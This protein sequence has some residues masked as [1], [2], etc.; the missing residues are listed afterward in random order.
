MFT[1]IVIRRFLVD[2]IQLRLNWPLKISE[3]KHNKKNIKKYL[4]NY[5]SHKKIINVFEISVKN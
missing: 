2:E 1:K 5:S 3:T 4:S